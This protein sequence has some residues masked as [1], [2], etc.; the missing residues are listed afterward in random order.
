MLEYSALVEKCRKYRLNQRIENAS[1]S[2]AAILFQNLFIAAKEIPTD[3]PKE[4]VIQCEEPNI[5]FYERYASTIQGLMDSGVGVRLLVGAAHKALDQDKFLRAI[6]THKSGDV[7]FMNSTA[8]VSVNFI[9]VG[10][11]SYRIE[12]DSKEMQAVANFNDPVVST[13]M[14]QRFE[15]HWSTRTALS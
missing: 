1:A 6:D 10:Q 11:S 15:R 2:H 8:D 4:I 5:T 13:L 7:A 9:V 3:E 14:R 12:N